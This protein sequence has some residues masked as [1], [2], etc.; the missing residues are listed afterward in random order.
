MTC[1]QFKQKGRCRSATWD[2]GENTEF[3][4]IVSSFEV[5]EG[6]QMEV[7]SGQLRCKSGAQE[8]GLGLRQQ[9]R[10]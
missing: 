7:T 8:K 3:I 5:P 10:N 2:L 4:W 6:V 9:H 1:L